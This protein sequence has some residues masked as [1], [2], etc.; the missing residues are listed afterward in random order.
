MWCC[1]RPKQWAAN[2]FWKMFKMA[3]SLFVHYKSCA[4]HCTVR[5]G[6]AGTCF[7]TK[8]QLAPCTEFTIYNVERYGTLKKKFTAFVATAL[9]SSPWM[10]THPS[11]NC[12]PSCWTSVFLRVTGTVFPTSFS[13]RSRSCTWGRAVNP[14]PH[15]FYVLPP[16]SAFNM[17]IQGGKFW[18]GK[19]KNA[20]KLVIIE[21]LFNKM[22]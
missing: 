2:W 6:S 3:P 4:R 18:G 20:K 15:S 16:G 10:V 14:D 21:L 17:R 5:Y 11:A 19:M 8:S 7:D 1:I 9:T 22:K 12:C 13:C